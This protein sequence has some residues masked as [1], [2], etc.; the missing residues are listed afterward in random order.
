MNTLNVLKL[1]VIQTNFLFKNVLLFF[2]DIVSH[3]TQ[4]VSLHEWRMI[5]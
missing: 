3:M 2:G 1:N 5:L 4:C